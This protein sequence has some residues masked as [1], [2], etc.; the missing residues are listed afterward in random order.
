MTSALE[1][2][3]AMNEGDLM[4]A[5]T[6][7]SRATAA[8]E[9]AAAANLA[10]QTQKLGTE[11]GGT[12]AALVNEVKGIGESIGEWTANKVISAK[13]GLAKHRAFQNKEL[14][15]RKANPNY[16]SADLAGALFD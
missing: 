3:K 10:A 6:D 13:E 5:Q 1:A 12:P 8:K 15:K 16:A 4:Q 2:Y 14:I 11:I 7:Q 9:L